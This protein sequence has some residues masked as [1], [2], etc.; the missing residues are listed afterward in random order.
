MK[1]LAGLLLVLGLV[2][3]LSAQIFG[4][5]VI[6]SGNGNPIKIITPSLPGAQAAT[7][8]INPSIPPTAVVSPVYQYPYQNF[9]AYGHPLGLPVHS[10]AIQHGFMNP[11]A[12]YV[13]PMMGPMIIITRALYA[14]SAGYFRTL[15]T[16]NSNSHKK[17]P[18]SHKLA[19]YLFSA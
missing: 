11:P 16:R 2:P 8:I 17:P 10:M 19:V 18:F 7:V 5:S 15:T 3:Q 12:L 13:Q 9:Q 14:S 6:H 4:P 1:R